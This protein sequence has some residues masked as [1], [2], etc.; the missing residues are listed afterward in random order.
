[1]PTAA[2]HI[3]LDAIRH[4]PVGG[5]LS[6][7][8]VSW[9]DYEALLEELG[10]RNA[11]RVAYDDGRLEI[12]SPSDRHERAKEFI[13]NV[14]RVLADELGTE[15]ES[16]GS[17]TFKHPD[18]KKGAE[19]DTSFYVQHAAQVIGRDGLDLTVD[20]PPDVVVE[21]DVSHSS[22]MKL[23]VWAE[24]GVPE[25]WRYDGERT[26]MYRRS[27]DGYVE[28]PESLAFPSFTAETLAALL[29]RLRAEGQQAVLTA[30]RQSLRRY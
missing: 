23:R 3:Y 14:A 17:T 28:V 1:M 12:V 6:I 20:P 30:F 5:A 24:I 10:D 4:L 16:V 21:V 13:Q 26:V 11:V 8:G 29:H 27:G 25:V 19:P 2:T 18:L 7:P 22:A 9:A 15:L